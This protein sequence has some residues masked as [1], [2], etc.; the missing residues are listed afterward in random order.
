ME[1][2]EQKEADIR[3]SMVTYFEAHVCSCYIYTLAEET[4]CMQ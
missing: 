2:T 4:D 3:L 1:N